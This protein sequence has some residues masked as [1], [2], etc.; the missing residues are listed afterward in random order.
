MA[1]RKRP[2]IKRIYLTEQEEQ[3]IMKKMELANS[4][5][6]TSYARKM[7]LDGY[8]IHKDFSDLLTL[9]NVLSKISNN[10][11]QINNKVDKTSHYNREDQRMLMLNHKNLTKEINRSLLKKIY[12]DRGGS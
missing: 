12:E 8:V 6:F 1:A 5:N 9:I 4:K 11:R 7:L 3:T 10:I 2:I